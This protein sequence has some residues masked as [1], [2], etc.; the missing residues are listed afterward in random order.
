MRYAALVVLLLLGLLGSQAATAQATDDPFQCSGVVVVPAGKAAALG[1]A[2]PECASAR[3]ILATVNGAWAARVPNV[4]WV[5]RVNGNGEVFRVTL[6]TR[7]HVADVKVAW[8]AFP[9]G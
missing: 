6:N 1:G 9:T 3:N 4:L 8:I 2:G 5:V 7:R